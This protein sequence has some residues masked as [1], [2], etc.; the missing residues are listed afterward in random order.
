MKED[1]KKI[2]QVLCESILGTRRYKAIVSL[3][4]GKQG[5]AALKAQDIVLYLQSR[6]AELER[7]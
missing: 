5:D 4:N 6:C 3:D 2:L 1:T 7:K